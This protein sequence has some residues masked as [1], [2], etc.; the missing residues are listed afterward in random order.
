MDKK[1]KVTMI[2]LITVAAVVLGFV[3]V[4]WAVFGKDEVIAFFERVKDFINRPL[5]IIG[6]SAVTLALIIFK[7][8]SMSSWGKKALAEQERKL[9]DF[10]A[11]QE[12]LRAEDRKAFEEYKTDVEN[13]VS[14]VLRRQG[15]GENDIAQVEGFIQALPF[16]GAREF[17]LEH[18]AK[19]LEHKEKEQ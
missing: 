8:V 1:K 9:K 16:K 12:Q 15:I 2:A 4:Y 7:F 6:F 17:R 11:K 3:I 19:A 5:P 18:K 14:E 13:G 10:E